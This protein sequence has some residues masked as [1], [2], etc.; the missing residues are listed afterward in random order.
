M[1][2]LEFLGGTV[3]MKIE[4]TIKKEIISIFSKNIKEDYLLILFGSFVGNKATISSDIDLAF[5]S[6]KRIQSKVF[7]QLKEELDENVHTLREMDLIDLSDGVINNKL[8]SNVLKGKI[9]RKPKNYQELLKNLE[10]RL[11]NTER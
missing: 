5:Y 1:G 11:L 4:T 3:K 10:K 6:P 8:L 9:W 2:K 7:M